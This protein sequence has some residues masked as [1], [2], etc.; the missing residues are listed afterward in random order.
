MEFIIGIAAVAA[1]TVLVVAYYTYIQ[2]FRADSKRRDDPYSPIRGKQYEENRESMLRV[3]KIMDETTCEDVSIHSHDGLTLWGRYY[4]TRDGAPLQIL[5]HGYRS[6]ALRDCAGM[7]ILAKKMGFNVLAV[8][9][10]SHGRSEGRVITF[11]IK[12]RHDC[13]K[14]VA[15]AADRFGKEVPIILSGLSMGAAT[16]LMASEMKL[17]GNVCCVV[18]DCPY[19]SPKTIIRKVCKDRGFPEKLVYPFISVGARFFGGFSP[20]SGSAEDSAKRSRLPVLLLHGEADRFV[21]CDMSRAIHAACR[22]DCQLHTFPDA[23]HCLCYM[24]DPLRYE[25]V[26]T[27]FLWEI[28]QLRPSME[29][30]EFVQKQLR[31]EMKY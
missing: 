25:D 4:H 19:S 29:Q 11:G 9:Q 12:E 10:R 2:C 24:I 3:T 6:L 28:P 1:I 17:P 21:P 14:W 23:G 20:E 18:A 31:G 30:S 16:V 13:A 7:F 5:F 8:D 15:Y 26:V 27:R 22:S